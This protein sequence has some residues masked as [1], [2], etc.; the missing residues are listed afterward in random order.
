MAG[1]IVPIIRKDRDEDW[2]SVCFVFFI[3]SRKQTHGMVTLMF[4][5]ALSISIKQPR[6]SLKC[7]L[8][9]LSPR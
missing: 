8:T 5:V 6:N 1:H 7:M 2:C 3:Q 9:G 4:R